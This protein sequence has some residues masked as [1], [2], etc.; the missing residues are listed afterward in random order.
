M[1][2]SNSA[3]SN[4]IVLAALAACRLAGLTVPEHP[5]QSSQEAAHGEARDEVAA[6]P[7]ALWAAVCAASGPASREP[8]QAFQ[9][10]AEVRTRSGVQTNEAR[11]EYRYLAP[12]CIRFM[13][14]SKN[15]TGRFG[16][17]PEHY[18]LRTGERVVALA[19]REF[20][21]DRRAV[22]DMLAL[23][24]NY[25]ALSN[26][27]R[28][29]L[30]GLERPTAPPADLGPELAKKLRKLTWLAFE[31]PDF[32]LVKREATGEAKNGAAPE[33]TLYRIELG[34]REDHL[35]AVAIVREPGKAGADPLLVMFSRYEA[36]DDF[37]L[38]FVLLVHVL[39]R[40]ESPARFAEKPSQEVYVTSASLRPKL[41]VADFQP[42]RTAK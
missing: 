11:I 26:P 41:S 25:V 34:L 35:P 33:S 21:E 22:D 40:S 2:Y 37:R 10:Q 36:S 19:G 7:E 28:L 9:L 31:S 39:D 29:N 18:W 1:A 20:K 8:L 6:T 30:E 42:E 38:P 32:A 12:D 4:R 5:P 16:P 14:P 24:K 17:A 13:L 3:Y 27:A 23:A 15:E